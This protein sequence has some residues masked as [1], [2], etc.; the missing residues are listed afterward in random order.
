MNNLIMSIWQFRKISTALL[1]TFL[2]VGCSNVSK[3]STPLAADAP[4]VTT[5]VAQSNG[6]GTNRSI[7]VVFSKPMDPAS[8]NTGSFV[9]SG[10]AGGCYPLTFIH[11]SPP[12]WPGCPGSSFAGFPSRAIG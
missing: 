9:V 10:V 4:S 2:L 5:V 3:P 1:L 7:A 11:I 6:V 8:I 12:A